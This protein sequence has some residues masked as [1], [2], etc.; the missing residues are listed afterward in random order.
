MSKH[1]PGPW[2]FHEKYGTVV[3]KNNHVVISCSI[4]LASG[5]VPADDVSRAND[6]LISAAPELLE[7]LER[8]VADLPVRRD[9]LDPVVER[10]AY[11][12]IAKARGAA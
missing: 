7:S 10:A 2:R 11:A 3:D 12:A 1:A 4:S 5:Y 6:R 8:I 9:W